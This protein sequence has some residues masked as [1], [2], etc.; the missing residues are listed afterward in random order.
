MKRSKS[1]GKSAKRTWIGIVAIVLLV[2]AGLIG[3]DTAEG[4]P[5]LDSGKIQ[6]SDLVKGSTPD[7]HPHSLTAE[8]VEAVLKARLRGRGRDKIAQLARHFLDLCQTHHFDPAFVLS[9]IEKES[10][11]RTFATSKVGAMGLMQVMPVTAEYI[12]ERFEIT[13]YHHPGDLRDPFI[14]MQLG[15]TYLG[16]LREQFQHSQRFLA[17][18]NLGPTTVRRMVRRG[19]KLDRIR[20]YVTGIEGRE[21]SMRQEA[22]R[23]GLE[24]AGFTQ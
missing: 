22:R 8:D 19:F 4:F 3:S 16:Y 14:N 12:A 9:L 2:G 6:M 20:K 24:L 23:L 21:E 1:I 13:N 11:F 10:G 7:S 18:Y 17:A 5:R 15:I